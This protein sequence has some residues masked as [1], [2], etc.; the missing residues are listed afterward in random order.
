MWV[1]TL[2]VL[3]M[4]IAGHSLCDLEDS[5][6]TNLSLV[7]EADM[8]EEL[9]VVWSC[10]AAR[11]ILMGKPMKEAVKM[12]EKGSSKRLDFKIC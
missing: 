6:L 5:H 2:P 3:G 1:V 7:C 8:E 10:R 4:D 11:L 12:V 9:G